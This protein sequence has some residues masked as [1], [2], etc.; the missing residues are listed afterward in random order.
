MKYTIKLSSIL[1]FVKYLKIDCIF[2]KIR[3]FS[4]T[5]LIRGWFREVHQNGPKNC[6]PTYKK[7]V[8]ILK[9]SCQ[10]IGNFT[11]TM[12]L[13]RIECALAENCSVRIILVVGLGTMDQLLRRHGPWT[14]FD[15]FL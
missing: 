8:I 15:F 12:A 11:N 1:S 13:Q 3:V 9:S 14:P 7:S 10:N 6:I 5:E 4:N 2:S